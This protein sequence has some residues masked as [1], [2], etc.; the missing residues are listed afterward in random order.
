[1][2]ATEPEGLSPSADLARKINLLMD[3]AEAEGRKVAFKDVAAAMDTAGT[4]L[5]RARWHYMRAGTGPVVKKAELLK[6]LAKFFGVNEGYL[7]DGD[8]ELP[9]RVEA[10]M[11]LLTTMREKKVRN[12]AARQLDGLSPEALRQIRDLIDAR[13][14][15]PAQ[16]SEGLDRD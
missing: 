4:P 6:N 16:E 15:T 2:T 12:F 10:Q 3:T 5:S 7:L 8:D 11:E 13:L 1:M 9:E 14:T